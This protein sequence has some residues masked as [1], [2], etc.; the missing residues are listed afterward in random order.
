MCYYSHFTQDETVAPSIPSDP[1]NCH[2][3]LSIKAA[4][5]I[6]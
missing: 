1:L 2:G 4:K 3:T 6:Y 5:H